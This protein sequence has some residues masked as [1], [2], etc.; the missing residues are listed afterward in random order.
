M[1]D[2]SAGMGFYNV[3]G[4]FGIFLGMLKEILSVIILVQGIRLVNF[5]IRNKGL[6]NITVK[7]MEKDK[8]ESDHN[9]YN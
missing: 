2:P 6:S 9:S 5:I 1:I 7:N 8:E 3:L 4:V